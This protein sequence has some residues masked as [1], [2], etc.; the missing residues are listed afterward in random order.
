M[1]NLLITPVPFRFLA[2]SVSLSLSYP[3]D[4]FEIYWFKTDPKRF[5]L[6]VSNLFTATYSKL[7]QILK[8]KLPRTNRSRERDTRPLH[9][10]PLAMICIQKLPPLPFRRSLYDKGTLVLLTNYKKVPHQK[11]SNVKRNTYQKFRVVLFLNE[12]S[13][14]S[15]YLPW[16]KLQLN[17]EQ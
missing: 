15:R 8:L 17:R 4:N 7:I 14:R 5:N 2:L 10:D 12:L 6:L 9:G 3:N 13:C 16:E 1:L 11:Q